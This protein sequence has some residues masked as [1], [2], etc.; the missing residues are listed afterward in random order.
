MRGDGRAVLAESD[1]V[2]AMELV[3]E[4]APAAE[5]FLY[6]SYAR[7][8]A[9]E[10]SD[11]DLLVVEPVVGVRSAE[12]ARLSRVLAAAGFRADVLVVSRASF[13]EWLAVPG[14]IER[15]A[16]PAGVPAVDFGLHLREF[17]SLR[18]RSRSRGSR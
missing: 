7:G 11:L 6:G 18:S 10:T 1:I 16:G 4:A 13:E 9:R 15:A 8:E 12:A 14:M 17:F 2:E 5:V 3:R